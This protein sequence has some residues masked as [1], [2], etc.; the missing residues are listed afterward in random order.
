MNNTIGCNSN[1]DIT[2]TKENLF[3]LIDALH[4]RKE[5]PPNYLCGPVY[6]EHVEQLIDYLK[7]KKELF[8]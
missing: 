8:N 7:E 5:N 4:A 6:V 1:I 2:V 3:V